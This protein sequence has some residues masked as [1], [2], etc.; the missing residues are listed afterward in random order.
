MLSYVCLQYECIESYADELYRKVVHEED[1]QHE[2]IMKVLLKLARVVDNH[3]L[4]LNLG[5]LRDAYE[6]GDKQEIVDELT[7]F[8]HLAYGYATEMTDSEEDYTSE[9]SDEESD[10]L[11][12]YTSADE[13]SDEMRVT[14]SG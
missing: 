9:E 10:E 5:Y 11:R 12:D 4:D 14:R 7:T 8:M 2:E 3:V 6:N 13:R 1:F